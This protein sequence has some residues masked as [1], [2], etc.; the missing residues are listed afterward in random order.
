MARF[1]K[2][3][4][5]ASRHTGQQWNS[6]H[7]YAFSELF[8]IDLG[9][10]RGAALDPLKGSHGEFLGVTEEAVVIDGRIQHLIVEQVGAVGTYDFLA[11][12]DWVVDGARCS[13]R[14]LESLGG[15]PDFNIRRWDGT[16]NYNH[17][18]T[19]SASNGNRVHAI[20][21]GSLIYFIQE[22]HATANGYV[23]YNPTSG[24]SSAVNLTWGGIKFLLVLDNNVVRI[25]DDSGDVYFEWSKDGDPSAWTAVGSGSTTISRE[26]GT[27]RGY[28]MVGDALILVCDYGAVRVTS[29]GTLPA[30]RFDR[31]DGVTGCPQDYA[32]ASNG[33]QLFYLGRDGYIWVTEGGPPR[34]VGSQPTKMDVEVPT[35]FHWL[36]RVGLLYAC[37]DGLMLAIDSSSTEIVGVSTT[38]IFA[39]LVAD[40]LA[41][42]TTSP[43]YF[44]S[45]NPGSKSYLVIGYEDGAADL[46]GDYS[47]VYSPMVEVG[48][49]IEVLWV[50]VYTTADDEPVVVTCNI[51]SYRDGASDVTVATTVEDH[52][53]FQRFYTHAITPAFRVVLRLS[54]VVYAET[55]G[56]SKIRVVCKATTPDTESL[57]RG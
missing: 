38:N 40:W 35:F 29:T 26:F 43:R 41:S 18:V 30:F 22:D 50:D 54:Q 7:Q 46:A 2:G 5:S 16:T 33:T 53:F 47:E 14:I 23:S 49:E 15:G 36:E 3:A 28:G 34:R 57:L 9:P 21:W 1:R 8:S 52:G 37:Q 45:A 17:V 19:A 11:I 6:G 12:Y 51:E 42:G 48:D 32:V 39:E 24:A 4:R 27:P 44:Q 10:W 20:N 13:V 31:L 25:Y 56:V 55:R